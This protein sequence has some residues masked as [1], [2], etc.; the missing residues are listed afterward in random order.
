MV[1]E[2]RLQASSFAHNSS[3]WL[4]PAV[5]NVITGTVSIT[6]SSNLP[7]RLKR[8]EKICNV[9][10]VEDYNMAP[11]TSPTLVADFFTTPSQPTGSFHSD[12]V[13]VDS[14]NRLIQ[15]I[16]SKF[17]SVHRTYGDVFNR[18]IGLYNG[19]SGPFV[20]NMN[21]TLPP[22]REGRCPNYS[23][24]DEET[25]HGKFNELEA[26]GIFATSEF[27]DVTSE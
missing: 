5:V 26:S 6:N 25:L 11:N 7:I 3:S 14:A 1:I 13:T 18:A 22:Q 4:H 9:R 15:E 19:A 20:I 24:S 16:H 10:H 23:H 12:A 21:P 17:T 27:L 2:P 8:N